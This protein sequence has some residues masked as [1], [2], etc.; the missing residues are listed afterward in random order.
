MSLT[1]EE[2]IQQLM[3]LMN[4]DNFLSDLN[5]QLKHK[6]PEEQKMQDLDEFSDIL[7]D[8]GFFNR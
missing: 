8:T 3:T 2:Y 5:S 7:S 6:E 4:D 1:N